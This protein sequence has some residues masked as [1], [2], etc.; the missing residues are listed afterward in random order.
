MPSLAPIATV[1]V[2]PAAMLPSLMEDTTCS[3]GESEWF[4]PEKHMEELSAAMRSGTPKYKV[5]DLFG[6]SE[7]VLQI[8]RAAGYDGCSFDIKLRPWNDICSKTGFQ[9]LVRHGSSHL[10]RQN[11]ANV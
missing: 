4:E 9:A 2:K 8:F 5:L 10:G 6:A 11:I 7:K 1:W 3:V